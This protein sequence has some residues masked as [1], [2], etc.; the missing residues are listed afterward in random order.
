MSIVLVVFPAAP[1]PSPDAQRAD[2]ELDDTLRT[3]ITGCYHSLLHA[4]AHKHRHHPHVPHLH[5]PTPC[6]NGPVPDMVSYTPASVVHAHTLNTV[7]RLPGSGGHSHT[8]Q[9]PDTNSHTINTVVNSSDAVTHISDIMAHIPH[10]DVDTSDSDS[11]SDTYDTTVTD[12]RNI[13]KNAT[14]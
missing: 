2:R 6:D 13:P 1:K 11:K 3:R 4:C 14:G 9:C 8:P 12:D 10:I 5:T 7:S